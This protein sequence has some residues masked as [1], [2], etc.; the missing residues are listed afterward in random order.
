MPTGW[1]I[2][3][4][5]RVNKLTIEDSNCVSWAMHER[6]IIAFYDSPL[7]VAIR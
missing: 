4:L 2:R 3:L 6:S 1:I 5:Q 7:I